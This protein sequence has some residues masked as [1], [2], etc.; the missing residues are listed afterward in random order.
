M[1]RREFMT[2]LG[3]ATAWPQMARAQQP[4]LPVVGF[5]RSTAAAGSVHLVD[6]FR[7]GLTEAGFVDGQNVT[8]EYRWADDL[9]NRL[10]ALTADLVQRH[11]AVIVTN[12]IGVRVA[13]T[14]TATTPLV[15]VAGSGPVR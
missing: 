10:A 4:A 3:G 12:S 15:F 9:D 7:Q 5:L 6:A 14:V 11:A 8:I 13:R 1:R 2:L